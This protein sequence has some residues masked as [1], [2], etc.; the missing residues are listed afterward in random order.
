MNGSNVRPDGG[1]RRKALRVVHI[2]AVHDCEH[3]LGA[4]IQGFSLQRQID[5]W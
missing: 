3:V 4:R 1:R 2:P 5:P